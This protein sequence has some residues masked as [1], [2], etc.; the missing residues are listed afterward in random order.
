MVFGEPGVVEEPGT[1]PQVVQA[2]KA[3]L[4]GIKG[5]TVTAVVSDRGIN[6]K[7]DVKASATADPTMR[8]TMDQIKDSMSNMASPLPEE[9]VGAG[10]KWQVKMPVKSQ[11]M[12]IDQTAD[13]QLVSV[14]GDHIST[15]ATLTQS[16]ANQKIQNPAM[17]S[18]Q[19]NLIKMTNN[20]TGTVATDLSKLIPLQ[21][22]IDMHM[23][24][25]SEVTVGN[26]KQ[27]VA[28]KMA[29]NMTM[30]AK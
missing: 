25:N 24:M 21:A 6:K 13:Y 12:S 27:P 30:E 5:L 15:T 7:I 18:V 20:A 11:G 22:T 1:A 23:D 2:M 4:A 9:A 29:M 28:M 8:Q 10:A 3:Q 14:D 17:G 16:A 19:M 26:K